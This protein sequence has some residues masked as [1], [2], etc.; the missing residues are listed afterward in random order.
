MA[1][2]AFG[3]LL[4]YGDDI[5]SLADT[6]AEIAR[7]KAIKPPKVAAKEIDTTCLDSPDEFEEFV[8]GLANGGELEATIEYDKT[9]HATLYAL[10]RDVIGWRI[11]YPD[12]SGWIFDGALQ[13]IGDEE[14]ANGEIVTATIKIKVS[15]RP[16]QS[17]NV[18]TS[19]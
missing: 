7:V 13:E 16:L 10:F 3:T 11:H 19:S 9:Q 15:G 1:Q 5:Y 18:L 6:W 4:E 17:A 8:M 2:K 14:V 12:H